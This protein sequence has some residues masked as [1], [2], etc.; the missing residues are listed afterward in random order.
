MCVHILAILFGDLISEKRTMSPAAEE[1][2]VLWCIE[3]LE[4]TTA[5]PWADWTPFCLRAFYQLPCQFVSAP[6]AS[7]QMHLLRAPGSRATRMGVCFLLLS[8]CIKG[9]WFV[10]TNPASHMDLTGCFTA[11]CQKSESSLSFFFPRKNWRGAVKV[12]MPGKVTA[13]EAPS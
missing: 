5:Q 13:G 6:D 3:M 1:P 4:M 2:V 10:Q 12:Q 7:H 9:E 8:V 11:L